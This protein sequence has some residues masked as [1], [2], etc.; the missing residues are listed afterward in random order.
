MFKSLKN[1]DSVFKLSKAVTLTTIVCSAIVVLLTIHWSQTMI[2]KE[3]EK[4][5]V[6]DRGKS[7]I[8]ALSQDM[9]Q[10]RPVEARSHVKMFH[11]LFFTLSPDADA[12]NTNIRRALMLVDESGYNYYNDLL[13]AGYYS[14][15]ISA[16]VIQNITVDSIVVDYEYYPYSVICYA[17][18]TLTRQSNVTT[19]SLVTTSELKNVQRSD[20]NPHGF[21]MVGFRVIQNQE[22]SQHRTN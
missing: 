22:I 21:L 14:R 2:A 19:R 12:I 10:N 16:N 3:R 5:Y 6:L 1:I 7:L 11:E 8:L 15:I 18:Q 9:A 4:I 20:G 17:T 13:E